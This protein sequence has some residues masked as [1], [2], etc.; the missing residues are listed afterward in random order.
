MSIAQFL[1]AGIAWHC[2][3]ALSD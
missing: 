2:H 1:M 3:I